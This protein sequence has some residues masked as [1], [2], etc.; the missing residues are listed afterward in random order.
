MCLGDKAITFQDSSQGSPVSSEQACQPGQARR[1]EQ[2][3]ADLFG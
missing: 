3:G 1:S 2:A